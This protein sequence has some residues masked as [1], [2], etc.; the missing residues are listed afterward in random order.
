MKIYKKTIFIFRR[1]LR[2]EDNLGLLLALEKSITVIPIFIMTPEQLVHNKFKSNNSVQFMMESLDNLN[3]DLKKKKAKLYYFYGTPD[4]IVKKLIKHEKIDAIFV[5]R[6]Y[7]S[8]SKSRDDSIKKVCDSYKVKFESIED[9]LL[10]PV[11]TAKTSN[12]KIYTKF[13]PFFNNARQITIPDVKKNNYQNYYSKNI[14]FEFNDD[15]KKFYKQNDSISVHGGRDLGLEILKNIDQFKKYNDERNILHKPTTRLSAYIK[16]GCVSIREVYHEIKKKLGLKNDLIKQLFWREFYYN[17]GEY[18]PNT[19]IDDYKK[20]LFNQHYNRV[21]WI[22][23][24]TAT[25]KQKEDWEAWCNGMTGYPI[26]DAAMRQLNKIGYMENR[27]RLIVASF[28]TKNMSFHPCDGELYF[29]QQLV[30]IDVL[31]NIGN[32]FWVAGCGSDVQ[33]FFRIFSPVLQSKKF[34]PDCKYIKK[35]IPELENVE[36]KHIH[37]WHLYHKLYPKTKYPKPILDYSK[38][39]KSAIQKYKKGLYS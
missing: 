37:E 36:N 18:Y 5:N 22:T 2:L 6:D 25:E 29:S 39:A 13:T 27:G 33:P 24:A 20:K 21:K 34:D 12:N 11:G 17:I 19:S 4:K 8:Y 14:T 28:L 7:T 15:K 23:Y 3:Q 10:L 9:I 16:F 26:V 32:W 1:D 31:V 30:D 38:T 35:W